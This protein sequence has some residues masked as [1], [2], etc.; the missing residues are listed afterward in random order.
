MTLPKPAD[1]LLGAAKIV[2]IIACGLLIFIMV[3][4][5]IG[6]GA[7]TTVGRVE[8]LT[9]LAKLGAPASSI[10]LIGT[11]II[12]IF[13]LVGIGYQ[14]MRNLL[15]MI[16]SVGEGDPF[17]PEN[18]NRLS[19]MGW[20]T[21]AGQVIVLPIAAISEH[22]SPYLD[23]ADVQ[24]DFGFGLDLGTVLLMLVLFI[25][26]R[27]FRKGTQMREELEGTV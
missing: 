2:T 21:L 24:S 23:K 11:A 19:R 17:H 10:W 27:V 7:M 18:A 1:P 15:G 13:A 8:L 20:L 6:L 5:G 3:M 25:L 26:A 22:F 12:L 14:F 9:E 4:L 16:N